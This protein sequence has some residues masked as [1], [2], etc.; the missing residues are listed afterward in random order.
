MIILTKKEGLNLGECEDCG[1]QIADNYKV[2]IGCANKRKAGAARVQNK[3]VVDALGKL[4][5]NL[6]CL[7]RQLGVI[8]RQKYSVKIE[9]DKKKKDFVENAAEPVEAE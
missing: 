3:D 5:N 8:L 9:W 4:N 6:Y 7:R 2:C 1:A